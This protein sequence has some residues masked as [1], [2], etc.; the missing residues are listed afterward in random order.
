MKESLGIFA[1]EENNENVSMCK[2][3]MMAINFCR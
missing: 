2:Y 3:A 1:G